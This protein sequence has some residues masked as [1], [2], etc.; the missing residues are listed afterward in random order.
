MW[1]DVIIFTFSWIANSYEI[2]KN[3]NPSK[4]NTNTIT[5]YLA[6]EFLWNHYTMNLSIANT[7]GPEINFPLSKVNKIWV[8]LVGTKIFVFI[9]EDFQLL[10]ALL[11]E[12]LLSL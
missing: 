2:H 3:L 12:F 8:I 6:V 11:R 9:M 4:L 1:S 5:E 10:E 7:L